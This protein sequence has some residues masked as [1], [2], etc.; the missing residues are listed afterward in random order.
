MIT[1]NEGL[2]VALDQLG[3]VYTGLAAL[4]DEHPDAKPEW[5]AVLAEGFQD[6]ARQL[7]EEIE[8]YTGVSAFAAPAANQLEDYIGY[9]REIDLDNRTLTLRN[10]GEI[11]EVA[12]TFDESLLEGAK[13]ALDRR[14]KI[15]G[16]RQNRPGNRALPTL[17]VSRLEILE[18]G[19]SAVAQTAGSPKA[20]T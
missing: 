9:L 2:R 4:R 19:A 1:S 18:D 15:S 5:L 20:M 10:V 8:T 6:H 3:R 12:C 7:R 13:V 11:R 17:H 14:V 16:V